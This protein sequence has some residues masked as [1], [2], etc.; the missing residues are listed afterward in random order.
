MRI[1]RSGRAVL[2]LTLTLAF[3]L[4]CGGGGGPGDE[5]GDCPDP[6]FTNLTGV[7]LVDE[8]S[9][10]NGC[11]NS[12]PQYRVTFTQ[13]GSEILVFGRTTFAMT[14]CGTRA[15]ANVNPTV[16]TTSGIITYRNLV[17]TFP[18]DTR[19]TGTAQ[20][21]LQSGSSTCDGS[22]TFTGVR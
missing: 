3:A 2:A 22:S 14:I 9:T 12:N 1:L 16:I 20:W 13:A 4:A 8:V 19:F 5:G 10:G 6:S 18:S 15:S 7:W 11:A 17:L 21:T